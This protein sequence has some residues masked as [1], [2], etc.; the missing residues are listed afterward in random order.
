MSQTARQGVVANRTNAA[1]MFGPAFAHH[2]C[3]TNDS[4]C[5]R[6]VNIDELNRTQ[7]KV[8]SKATSKPTVVFALRFWPTFRDFTCVASAPNP[9]VIADMGNDLRADRFRIGN[10]SVYKD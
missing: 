6:P 8:I 3:D 1:A 7:A 2:V 10:T 4:V 9:K 5:V